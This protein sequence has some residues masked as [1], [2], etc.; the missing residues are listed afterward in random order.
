MIFS[1]ILFVIM[2][3]FYTVTNILVS[4]M[5]SK[6]NK[7]YVVFKVYPLRIEIMYILSFF[8]TFAFLI[9]LVLTLIY[10]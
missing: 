4:R 6:E 7:E 8:F 3:L 5:S 9:S 1:L 2:L 10:T